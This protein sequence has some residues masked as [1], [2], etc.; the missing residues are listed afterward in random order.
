MCR[1]R[2]KIYKCYLPQVEGV[3]GTWAPKVLDRSLVDHVEV[4]TD[5]ESFLMAREL[6][7]REGLLC[8][9][10]KIFFYYH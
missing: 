5:Q 8:G 1:F 2:I 9:D 4:V 10:L 3:G 6:G 7:R